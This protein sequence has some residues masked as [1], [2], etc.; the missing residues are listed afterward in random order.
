MMYMDTRLRRGLHDSC[1]KWCVVSINHE[2]EA[3]YTLSCVLAEA[4]DVGVE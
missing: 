2:K 3:V 1:T 4:G